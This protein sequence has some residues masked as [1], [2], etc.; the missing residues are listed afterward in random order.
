MLLLTNFRMRS[1]V[2]E[3]H[4][5][6]NVRGKVL[7]PEDYDV[8]L[9]G[10]S[11]VYGPAGN[12]V[13]TY[14]PGVLVGLAEEYFERIHAIRMVTK[15]RVLA[16]GSPMMK[17]GVQ[18]E[19]AR[20]IISGTIGYL[21]AGVSGAD[22]I[23][24][25]TAWTGSHASEF[26]DLFPLFA[27]IGDLAQLYTP[28]EWRRQMDMVEKTAPE[29]VIG[30]TPYTT[31]TVNHDYP[32]GVHKD[33]G[34]LP[35]GISCL[36]YLARGQ[37]KVDGPGGWHGGELVFPSFRLA[38]DPGPGDLL[39][40]DAHQWHGNTELQNFDPNAG[41]ARTALVLYYR[42]NMVKCPSPEL[43]A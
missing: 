23:C 35:Q 28:Q 25:L 34:D 38:V 14:L 37:A 1:L 15:T 31:V 22:Q 7:A 40:M 20:E 26:A 18:N 27:A 24:R 32:T 16:S 30:D 6:K 13:V 19:A 12:H 5:R 3:A 42:T 9:T 36:F 39:L 8:L 4:I 29:F 17:A 33:A 21:E 43:P 2:D 11:R 41:H 10:P